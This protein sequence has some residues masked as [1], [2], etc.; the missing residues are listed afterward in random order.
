MKKRLII[1]VLAIT[2]ISALA[3]VGTLAYYTSQATSKDN[4]FVAGTLK[5]GG[6]INGQDV[7]EQ[8]AQL[9]G[10]G[11][12]KPGV[13]EEL[14][15]TT[16]KNVGTLPLKLYRITVSDL[17]DPANLDSV[18]DLVVKIGGEP[19]F[20]G[21][22]SQLDP[23]NGG[24]FD[25]IVNVPAGETR[26]MEFSIM[27]DPAAGNAFQGKTLNCD[28]SVWATQ[29]QAPEN[30]EPQ[31]THVN[32]GATSLFSVEGYNDRNYANFD[33]NWTP[34]D[35]L[36]EYY[37]LNIKHETG[38]PTTHIEEWRIVIFPGE[39]VISTDGID[40]ND[41]DVD[42]G[43]DIV[44]IKKSAIPSD[45]DGFEVQL[46]GKQTLV[47]DVKTIPYQYWSLQPRT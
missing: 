10:V 18:L 25:P 4:S 19:V 11:N 45:W 38:L 31:G 28:L 26:D 24:Y 22:L 23:S 16:L 35:V 41:V 47:G 39:K 40:K 9:N 21:K 2:L 17:Q 29:N 30:G 13:P 14:G 20:S 32:L 1:S 15:T 6:V 3:G 8:F 33:W 12:L 42:W 46:S 36:K 37:V 43:N 34:N 7:V 44:K 5:L 27:M